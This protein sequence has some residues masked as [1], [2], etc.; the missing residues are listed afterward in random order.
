[1]PDGW[2]G[3]GRANRESR[4]KNENSLRDRKIINSCYIYVN[5]VCRKPCDVS[6]ISSP[7]NRFPLPFPSISCF[8][9]ATNIR[10]PQGFK[11]SRAGPITSYKVWLC[12]PFMSSAAAKSY[13]IEVRGHGVPADCS[14]PPSAAR[15]HTGPSFFASPEDRSGLHRALPDS[16]V[17]QKHIFNNKKKEKKENYKSLVPIK[18]SSMSV[19][20]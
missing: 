7:W 12:L 16:F 9:L 19:V 18:Y 6:P 1:M 8:S 11:G 2:K 3:R 4:A 17:L 20:V 5:T 14:W 10:A 15:Q 13:G